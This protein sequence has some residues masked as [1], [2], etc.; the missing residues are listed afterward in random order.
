VC[1][2]TASP[3]RVAI[4]V[5]IN[6]TG[7]AQTEGTGRLSVITND[8]FATPSISGAYTSASF[9]SAADRWS[10][11]SGGWDGAAWRIFVNGVEDTTAHNAQRAATS[12]PANASWIASQSTTGGR[13]SPILVD[14]VRVYGRALTLAEIRLLASRRGIGLAPQRQRRTSASSKRLYL[15]VGGAWKETVPF[16]NVGGAWKEAAVYRHDGTSWKN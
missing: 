4:V 6:I 12:T 11:V 14:D 13:Y 8:T 5:G 1:Q 15:Q 9:S 10:H 7:Q 2:E 16:V 3:N